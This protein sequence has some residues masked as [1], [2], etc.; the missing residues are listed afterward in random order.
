MKAITIFGDDECSVQ[1]TELVLIEKDVL[2]E[3]IAND[4]PLSKNIVVHQYV[5]DFDR[6]RCV[7]A[8]Y[9][10][11]DEY[12]PVTLKTILDEPCE[13]FKRGYSDAK[14]GIGIMDDNQYLHHVHP[15]SD[16]YSEYLDGYS[17]GTKDMMDEL[18][19]LKS[20]AVGTLVVYGCTIY[21]GL[22]STEKLPF[23]NAITLRFDSV[24]DMNDA[25]QS[26]SA[27]IN[28]PEIV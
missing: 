5:K 13:A 4:E 26:G 17:S 10:A 22:A 8:Y 19:Q 16:D 3:T 20:Q 9:G 23:D 27:K 24:S 21:S 2:N 1:E 11:F 18:A 25:I 12:V 28:L 7:A 14:Q 15:D 6:K